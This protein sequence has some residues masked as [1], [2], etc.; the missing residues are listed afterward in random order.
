M[1]QKWVGTQTTMSRSHV[2]GWRL[3]NAIHPDVY[4]QSYRNDDWVTYRCREGFTGT[5]TRTCGQNGWTGDSQC[6]AITCNRK[7]YPNADIEG[8]SKSIYAYKEEVEYVCKRGYEGRF[9]LTCGNGRWMGSN[10]CRSLTCDRPELIN[11]DI[12][13]SVPREYRHNDQIR[14][15]CKHSE[16]VLVARCEQGVWT[17]FKSCSECPKPV[18]PNGFTS[19]S[20]DNKVYYTCDDGY[21]LFKKGWW[22][23]ATCKGGV[24]FGLEQCIEKMQCGETPLIPNGKVSAERK[25]YREGQQISIRCSEGFQPQVSY[26]RCQEGEWSSGELALDEICKPETSNC[27]APPKFDNAIIRTPF[28][29][30]YL[31]YS[32][33]VYECRSKYLLVGDERLQCQNGEWEKKN[34]TCQLYCEVPVDDKLTFTENKVKFLDGEVLHYQCTHHAESLHATCVDGK[35]NTTVECVAPDT[36]LDAAD[37]QNTGRKESGREGRNLHSP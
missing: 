5:P 28:Q 33:V 23:E 20:Q 31:S 14:Y 19:G 25:P 12:I 18:V 9:T 3:R 29:T 4:K 37:A 7:D 11:A 27:V 32:E 36:S 6:T 15:R 17:G 13:G 1:H 35:W 22:G 8:P 16:E 10:S 26:L 21:K 30:I 24:W 2:P 34:I